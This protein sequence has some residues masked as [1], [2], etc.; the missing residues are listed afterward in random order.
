MTHF[1]PEAFNF[2][3]NGVIGRAFVLRQQR[4]F[5]FDG[6]SD[7]T[8]RVDR[9]PL[10]FHKD[11]VEVEKIQRADSLQLSDVGA[12]GSHVLCDKCA[13]VSLA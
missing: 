3:K 2:R 12:R 13:K 10:I 4:P 11:I 8:A 1:L 5:V 7:D 9:L 6:K